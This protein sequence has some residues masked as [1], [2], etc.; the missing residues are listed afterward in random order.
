[1]EKD[2]D[3]IGVPGSSVSEMLYHINWACQKYKTF[4]NREELVKRCMKMV[5]SPNRVVEKSDPCIS[6]PEFWCDVCG[7]NP[8]KGVRFRC[9]VR[10]EYDLCQ[11]CY[12]KDLSGHAMIEMKGEVTQTLNAAEAF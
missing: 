1:M 11:I 3:G 7:M 10:K 5:D 12:D 9:T 2:G 6:H 4:Q 8:I